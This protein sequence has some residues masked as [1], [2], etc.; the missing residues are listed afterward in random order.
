MS[1]PTVTSSV[2]KA[3]TNS[4]EEQQK[5]KFIK[6]CSNPETK[7]ADCIEYAINEDR[8]NKRM[9]KIR[10]EILCFKNDGIYQLNRA[11][12]SE[13]GTVV[14]KDNKSMSNDG[15][16]E[17]VDIQLADGTHMKAPFGQIQLDGLGEDAYVDINYDNRAHRLLVT[18]KCQVRFQ[19]IM[20]DIQAAARKYLSESSIYKNQALQITDINEPEIMDL[21]SMDKQLMVLS[22]Q[23]ENDLRPIYARIKNP[24]KCMEKG[25]PLKYGALLEGGYGTGKTLLAFKLAKMAVDSGWMF[26]YLKDPKLLAES[27]RLSKTVDKSGWGVVLFVEDVDQVTSGDRDAAM[28]DILNTLDGG[29]TKDMNVITLFTTNHI[30]KI[31]P[32]FLRGKRI[33]SLISM[34]HLDEE[35]AHKFIL[36][37]L[38]RGG[39][40][41]KDVENM[42][43]ICKHVCA[44]KIVPAFMAEIL[45][46]VEANLIYKETEANLVECDEIKFAVDSYARQVQL[47][48]TKDTSKSDADK[49]FD[50]FKGLFTKVEDDAMR[51]KNMIA[52]HADYDA[53]DNDW[54]DQ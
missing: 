35:T 27:L 24:Q 7:Y 53:K 21:S 12:E 33:G 43:A 46:K 31:E 26:I 4:W 36:A 15:S 5:K 29:D 38:E 23:T 28:Q 37:Y 13:F 19:P 42:P 17:T 34:G 52:C 50:A 49:F 16:V 39:Y 32:T 8:Q 47:A 20:D 25:I 48:Q 1:T 14:S 41:I 22:K 9:A 44:N 3:K 51:A 18:G 30:E 54:K 40:G 11:I 2:V 10:F 45:E 6:I